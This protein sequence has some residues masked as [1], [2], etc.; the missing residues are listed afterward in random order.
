VLWVAHGTDQCI[1]RWLARHQ[2]GVKGRA[3][4]PQT[5]VL[6]R[7]NRDEN[8]R[9]MNLRSVSSTP[10][11]LLAPASRTFGF[12]QF[13]LP[14]VTLAPDELLLLQAPLQRAEPEHVEPGVLPWKQRAKKVTSVKLLI[15]LLGLLEGFPRLSS[16][17]SSIKAHARP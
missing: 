2:Q 4:D 6:K 8:V 13:I 10:A 11:L 1:D 17:C 9:V 16:L 5:V 7:T 12:L 3:H 14:A 15:C